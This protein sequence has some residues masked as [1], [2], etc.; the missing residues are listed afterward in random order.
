M[1]DQQLIAEIKNGNIPAFE[2]LVKKYQSKL[3]HFTSRYVDKADAE[4]IAQNTFIKIYQNIHKI[5]ST[6]KFTTYMFTIAKN[7]AFSFLR[8]H[9]REIP[10]DDMIIGSGELTIEDTGLGAA[11][12]KLENKYKKVIKLYYFDEL[13]YDQIAAVLKLPVNTIRTHLKRAKE[14]LKKTWRP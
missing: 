9:K 2:S 11:V 5:E 12:E 13:Q 8:K 10:I 4:D 3:I 6:K 1:D 14:A 7:E